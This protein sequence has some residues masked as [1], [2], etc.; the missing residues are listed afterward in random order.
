[1][2]GAETDARADLGLN[3]LDQ[4]GDPDAALAKLIQEQE[5]AWFLANGGSVEDLEFHD[6]NM[7]MHDQQQSTTFVGS[8]PPSSVEPGSSGCATPQ[9]CRCLHTKNGAKGYILALDSCC[10]R[11][12]M[13]KYT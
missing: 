11:K 9:A 3:G 5:H 6:S 8:T 10:S 13:C 12:N 7:D 4:E 2:A 1:M